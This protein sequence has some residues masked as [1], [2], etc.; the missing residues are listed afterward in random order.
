MDP[1]AAGLAGAERWLAE[2]T[3]SVDARAEAARRMADR[4][5]DITSSGSALDGAVR[6]TVGADGRLADLEIA[7]RAARVPMAEV[8]AAVLAAVREAQAGVVPQVRSVVEATVG[9]DSAEG[10]AVTATYA[11]RFPPP[12]RGEPDG[13]Q[14]WR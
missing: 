2:W 11:R 4:V 9:I 12:E 14:A 10:R 6:V 7:Q 3:T 5:R 1:D 8:A 13:S